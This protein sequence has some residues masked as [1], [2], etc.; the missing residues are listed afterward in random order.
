MWLWSLRSV[1]GLESRGGRLVV[2]G[3]QIQASEGF[4]RHPE[5]LKVRLNIKSGAT[6]DL[7]SPG[8]Q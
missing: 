7:P 2:A 1:S 4:L 5:H 8:Q 6:L 3:G